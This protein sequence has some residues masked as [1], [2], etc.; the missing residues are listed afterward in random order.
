M[1]MLRIERNPVHV[2]KDTWLYVNRKSIFMVHWQ[3][4]GG[5]RVV[6]SFYVPTK[7]LRRVLLILAM[8]FG[9]EKASRQR[10]RAKM[11]VAKSAHARK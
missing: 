11:G 1:S 10:R 7:T 8:Q 2:D 9:K 6:S 5:R 3:D 4:F